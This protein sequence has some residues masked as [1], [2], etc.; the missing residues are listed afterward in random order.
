MDN[1]SDGRHPN[2]NHYSQLMTDYN[3][4]SAPSTT[5][6]KGKKEILL[7]SCNN[8][9]VLKQNYGNGQLK[10]ISI[11]FGFPNSKNT[12]K[13][14][15]A[16]PVSRYPIYEQ[17][18]IFYYDKDFQLFKNK[19]V[20]KY[21]EKRNKNNA[22]IQSTRNNRLFSPQHKIVTSIKK[23]NIKMKVKINLIKRK[24]KIFMSLK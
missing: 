13:Y 3:K 18:N 19:S 10:N 9:S 1:L 22:S 12:Y 21:G 8:Y 11:N 14:K 4:N 16:F 7:K 24:K 17:R 5:S 15:N 20:S 6:N 23:K 2:R